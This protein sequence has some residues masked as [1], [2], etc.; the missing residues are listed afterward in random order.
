[1]NQKD[2]HFKLCSKPW[3]KSVV[4]HSGPGWSLPWPRIFIS[5]NPDMVRASS[6]VWRSQEESCCFDRFRRRWKISNRFRI[7]EYPLKSLSV[8]FP[9]RCHRQ[10]Y[11][12]WGPRC[13][14]RHSPIQ[15]LY[16]HIQRWFYV[17]TETGATYEVLALS[18]SVEV[19]SHLRQLRRPK[20]G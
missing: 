11:L 12:P 9:R 8:P 7:C 2:S 6:V 15:R 5:S 13:D 10:S 1:M 20:R 16:K 17:S 4:E 19:A 18:V 3:S 14:R